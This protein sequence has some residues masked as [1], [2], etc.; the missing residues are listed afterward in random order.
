MF[1]VKDI[2]NQPVISV[3]PEMPIYDAIRLLG[4]QE[5]HRSARGGR[6][7]AIDRAA[8]R[9]GRPEPPVQ[10][11]EAEGKTV[12]DFHERGKWSASTFNDNLVTLCD[13]LEATPS[14]AC[15]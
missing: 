5:R 11:P 14:V 8:V 7:P 10:Q 2:M 9:E 15:P 13:C 12:R 1:K 4:L 6:R 3:G